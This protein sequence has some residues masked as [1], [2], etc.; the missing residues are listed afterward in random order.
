VFRQSEIEQLRQAL[1]RD[2]ETLPRF[3]LYHTLQHGM[4]VADR[5]NQ[6]IDPRRVNEL[7]RLHGGGQALRQIGSGLMNLRSGSDIVDLSFH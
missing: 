2:V 3:A 5:G 1:R 4:H 7:L 6:N